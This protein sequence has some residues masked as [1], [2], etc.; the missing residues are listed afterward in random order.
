[1]AEILSKIESVGFLKQTNWATPQGAS[2]NF[3][4][5]QYLNAGTPNA[6]PDVRVEN[7]N[8]TSQNG[9]GREYER[10]FVDKTSGLPTIPVAG[11]AD[12]TTFAG[13]LAMAMQTAIENATT[14]YLKTFSHTNTVIDW[15]ADGGMVFTFALDQQASADDGV[16]LENCVMQNLNLVWDLNQNG[17]ARC[18]SYSGTVISNEINYE[19]TFSGT[20]TNATPSTAGF[21]ND[22]DLWAFS[23]L[24]IGGVAYTAQCI[25]RV[26]IQISNNFFSDC[27]TTGGKANQYKWRPEINLMIRMAHDSAT[28]KIHKDYQDGE[29]VQ[30]VWANNI[31]S[32]TDGHLSFSLPYCVMQSPP[33]VYEGDYI[34]LDI[35]AQVLSQGGNAHFTCTLADAIDWAFPDS[36]A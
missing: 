11:I 25:K 21:Y 20:W 16:I 7:I 23:T 33:K 28:E 24:S 6:N 8:S 35:N 22:T 29:R 9:P 18:L 2:A 19:Q 1:M 31:A 26:E 4:I 12:K 32:S 15:V 27:K 34:G 13:L 14:P 10:I 30:A 17:S 3:K 5:I 36:G